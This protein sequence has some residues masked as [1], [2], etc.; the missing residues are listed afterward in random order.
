MLTVCTC[1]L[2]NQMPHILLCLGQSDIKECRW[3]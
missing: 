2:N 3:T 1:V